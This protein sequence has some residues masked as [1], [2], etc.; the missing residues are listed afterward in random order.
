MDKTK[1][2]NL[3][4]KLNSDD[5]KSYKLLFENLYQDLCLHT[6]NLIFD[7]EVSRDIVQD[8][9]VKIWEDRKKLP[10]FQDFKAYVYKLSKNKA[11]NYIRSK[12]TQEN[13][14]A[15]LFNTKVNLYE[16]SNELEYSELSNTIENCIDSLPEL[17]RTIFR[18]NKFEMKKQI[19]VA[20][21]LNISVK[22]VESHISKA[23]REIKKVLKKYDF[24]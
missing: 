14:S 20:S 10:E 3:A 5:L 23:K 2:N 11:L 15:L 7:F 9:F 21:I 1:L 17:T 22:T 8:V 4:N 24:S 16:N 19:E 6:N 12:H 13:Y 18:L